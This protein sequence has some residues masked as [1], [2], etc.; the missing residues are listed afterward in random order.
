M[1]FAV[2]VLSFAGPF[3]DAAKDRQPTVFHRQV[4]D[5]LHDHDSLADAGPSE[6]PNFP[7][8]GVGRE[9]IDHLDAC[10]RDAHAK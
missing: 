6:K 9:Q 7:T 1:H 4:S 2:Q 5:H 8:R 10:F 3:P